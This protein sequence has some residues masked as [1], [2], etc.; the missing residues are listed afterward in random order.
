[1]PYNLRTFICI[2]CN[3]EFQ[4]RNIKAKFCSQ[5]C[6]TKDRIKTGKFKGENH[7][8][9]G[10]PR[11]ET[12]KKKIGKKNKINMK[13][14]WQDEGY[15]NH[16]VEVH[17]G[18]INPNKD[19]TFEEIYG[20]EQ[21]GK[22]RGEISKTLKRLFKEGK[23]AP[24]IGGKGKLNPMYGKIF[25]D[26]W[27]K[28]KSELMSGEKNP[29]YGQKHTEESLK[30]MSES[31]LGSVSPMKLNLP[32][33]EIIKL[34][35]KLSTVEIAKK[36]GCTHQPICRILKENNVK[37]EQRSDI[38]AK[39]E[40]IIE[41]YHKNF[42]MSKI[43]KLMGCDLC[44]IKRILKENNITIKPQNFYLK[45]KKSP[46][47][48]NLPEKEIINM[49]LNENISGDNI[50]KK[51]NCAHIV[52]YRILK[53]NNVNI[54]KIKDMPFEEFYGIERAKKIKKNMKKVR[55][56]IILPKKDTTIE[57]KI[58]DFLTLLKIE[59][60]THKYMNIKHSYQCDILIPEQIGIPQKTI[61]E[62]DGDFFHCNPNKYSADYV[63][64]P[65]SKKPKTAKE[66]WKL[67]NNR[68]K[69]LI[70][71]GFRVIRLWENEIRPMKLNDFKIKLKQ[72]GN[73]NGI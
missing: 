30:K 5:E 52:I 28:E 64:F 7:P 8:N 3:K 33:K 41:L 67:D 68:T 48:L 29:F 2:N 72:Q 17:I 12:T 25:S 9:Y 55:A 26:E 59:F 24:N 16:M 43:S 23:L 60:F 34:Y 57:L 44:V 22:M 71:K 69:E 18:Q 58:Q 19:K 45:G 1:M 53:E 6:C 37:I 27:R 15:R 10:K 40:K 36:F 62:C 42:P 13:R 35:E 11:L 14:L 21:A 66:K 20:E 47:R 51:F 38:W 49:Y 70:E 54:R 56:K 32:E 50:A 65:N 63:M 61:I 39:K 46:K 73:L 4:R 31:H